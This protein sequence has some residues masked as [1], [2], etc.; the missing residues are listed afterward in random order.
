[1]ASDFLSA[2]N[3]RIS[4]ISGMEI[5]DRIKR[6]R[7]AAGLTQVQLAERIG[8]D[9]SAVAQWES[10]A[11]RKGITTDNLL[12]VADALAISVARLAGD[13]TSADHL[14]TTAPDEIELLRLYRQ[15]GPVHK[16]AHLQ[17]FRASVGLTKPRKA[18]SNPPHGKRIA[19]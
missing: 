18:Q 7:M 19:S 14:E 11:S 9:K 12:K 17:V 3:S 8:V 10:P 5:G 16:D 6:E 13:D 1:M 15:M 4:D 2:G